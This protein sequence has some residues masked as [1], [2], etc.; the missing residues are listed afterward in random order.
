MT[1]PNPIPANALPENP[2]EADLETWALANPKRAIEFGKR[3]IEN[4]DAEKLRALE[5]LGA[6]EDRATTWAIDNPFK[7]RLMVL[8]LLPKL[9]TAMKELDAVPNQNSSV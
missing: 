7:A 2:T 8:R 5:S 3:L 1:D 6:D 9:M 4:Q